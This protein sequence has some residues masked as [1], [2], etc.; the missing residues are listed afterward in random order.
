MKICVVGATGRM[1]ALICTKL[2][3][4][5]LCSLTKFSRTNTISDL[6]RF[7]EDADLVIDFSHPDI[8]EN[9]LKYAQIYNTR[10]V[11]GTTGLNQKHFEFL[12]LASKNIPIFYSANMSFGANIVAMLAAKLSKITQDRNYDI[13]II[14]KHH[15]LKKDAPS[16]TSMMIADVMIESQG[17]DSKKHIVLDRANKLERRYDEIGICSVRGGSINGEHEV[18]FLGQND[19][20][21]LTHQALDRDIFVSGTIEASFWMLD[22]QPGLYSMQHL[23]KDLL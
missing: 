21:T 2:S 23:L 19:N 3:S 4:L 14:E 15:N 8:L 17:L 18:L 9:L 10:L 22:K 13:E 1:G 7:C 11:I 12:K 6:D 5:N 16:G 20:I